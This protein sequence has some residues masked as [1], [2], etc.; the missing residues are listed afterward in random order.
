[1]IKRFRSL[2]VIAAFLFVSF[3]VVTKLYPD[4]LWFDSLKYVSVWLFRVKAEFVT[5]FIFTV[6]A[7]AWLSLNVY[8]ANRNS[9]LSS[10]ASNFNIQT[11]FSFLNKLITQLKASF[12]Q[13]QQ[14]RAV[15]QDA[16]GLLIKGAV[17]GLSVLFGLSAK[18]WWEE[19]YL[20]LNQQPYGLVEPLFHKDVSFYL[21]SLPLFNHIQNW[22]V[23][24]FVVSLIFVGW[25]YF[26]R[27]ILLVFFSKEREFSAIKKHL[28]FLLSITFLLFSLG[29]WLGMF[30]LV[31]SKGGVVF[32]AAYTDVN[33]ILPVKKLLMVLFFLEAIFILFLVSRP[34]FKL[35]YILLVLIFVLNFFGLKMIP[36][37]V[38]NY[39][40]SPNELVKEKSFI[41]T[42][43]HFTREAYGLTNIEEVYFPATHELTYQDIQENNTIVDNIRLWNQEP[44][45]QTFS[46][47]QEIRLYYEFGSVDVDRYTINGKPQQVM[48][49]AR[50]LDSSQLTTQAQTWTNR[51]L[52]Y[53]HGYGL[54]MTPVN[55]VTEDG[56][57]EFFVKDLPPQY[58]ED[59]KVTHPAIYFGEKTVDYVVVN[60]EQKEFDYPKGDS[61]VYTRYEGSG[62]I[63]FDSLLTRLLYSFKFSDFKLFFSSLFTSDSR[64]M[65]DRTI[66]LISRRIAPFLVFDKDPY[67]VLTD[68]GRLKWVQDAYTLSKNFPYAE[69]F[70]GAVNYIRNSVKVVIDAYDGTVD[71]YLMDEKDPIIN[72]YAGIYKDLFK[73][74][75]EM[76][77]SIKKH[78]R[79]PKDLFSV[80]ASILNTYHMTDSQVFYNRED[81][82]EFPQETYEG[83]EKT[84]SPYYLVTKLPGEKKENFVLMLPFTPTN[85][86]N[87]IAWL[88]V[89]SDL[90][91]YGR[92][93]VLKLPKEKTIYG[94]MQ[95]ESRIDQHT[96]ISKDLTLW[97]QVGSR[98]IRGNLMIIPIEESLLYVEPIYLQATQSKLPELK[99]VIVSYEDRIVMAKNLTLAILE[100]FG[101]DSA[102]DPVSMDV[103]V[104]TS[105]KGFKTT[106]VDDVIQLFQGLKQQLK[107]GKWAAFGM[108]MEELDAAISSLK[109]QQ[110]QQKP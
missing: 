21:F 27:N 20:Y 98:V 102:P 94:P 59:L 22:F 14:A 84:M 88:A 79:Y 30:D 7:F 10:S 4:Y 95:I 71:F 92:F 42:N 81:L 33:I 97:G 18:T 13:T 57:P 73:P 87:M 85:K 110:K 53:T 104:K 43:I 40:V 75:N 93:T 25:I 50:E 89:S 80:Q 63:P 24:L 15:T 28:I 72:A 3:L 26:S 82:W 6:L 52:V 107:Q 70:N 86:N 74:L 78:V 44:L 51:H 12:D 61:N 46:Q 99:R 48:L 37:I 41:D 101:M 17:V 8:F 35:P 103:G 69:P 32:G 31:F 38:Q 106:N 60:T 91:S 83:S 16:Y 49:S 109:S 62:G 108:T 47:L 66:S 29:T 45:K 58:H 76:P 67:I 100:I 96:E 19:L 56:L 39:I 2:L 36:N 5:W 11:P 54:C 34:L 68:E 90:D 105:K 64:L 9:T 65:Y 1:M 23:G 77:E 55:K